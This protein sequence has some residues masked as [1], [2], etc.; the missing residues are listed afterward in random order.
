MTNSNVMKGGAGTVLLVLSLLV[1]VAG[2]GYA[3]FSLSAHGHAAFNASSN[4][5]W[6]QP[7]STYLYFALASSGLGLL[8]AIPL[9]FRVKA[10]YPV[11]KRCVFLAFIVL[12]SGM[13][14]LAMELGHTFR[15]IW[16]IPFGMQI[17]SAMFW[18]GV[19]YLLDLIFLLWKFQRLEGKDWDSKTAKQIGVASFLGVLLAS[20][21]LALIFGMM[22]MRPFW[23]DGSLPIY[24]YLTGITSGMAALVF[25]TYL[26]YGFKREAMP[27]PL[28]RLLT[29]NLPVLFAALLGV[30]L[31]FILVRMVTGLYSNMPEVHLV[32]SDYIL[33][34]PVYH[35]SLWG[36]LVLPFLLLLSRNLRVQPGVQ[37]LCAM[38][39]FAGLFAERY[40]FVVGGQ[41]IPL[42]KGTW[43]WDI[44]HYTPSAAEWSL[45]LM[46][47][48]MIFVLYVLGEKYFNLSDTPADISAPEPSGAT[49]KVTA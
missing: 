34:S 2:F 46:G 5:P 24:F 21:N 25:Y 29:G 45:T 44:V 41:V 8:A 7:I 15:M 19:L 36:G 4:V 49:A 14:V 10:Y 11:A 12:I 23:F 27:E 31:L 37:V 38:L 40:Y 33:T 17:E 3:A 43:A 9:V 18:M 30:T 35:L 28:Q 26:A 22:S 16:A 13:A 39:V 47:A 48:A 6:G 42:F 32:W 1:M 20:G